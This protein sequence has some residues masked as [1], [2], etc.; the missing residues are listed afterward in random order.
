M[1]EGVTTAESWVKFQKIELAVPFQEITVH[2]P[3]VRQSGSNLG[4]H[5]LERLRS[6]RY[7]LVGFT[8]T[9]GKLL[10]S[11]EANKTLLPTIQNI[12]AVFRPLD[13][14]LNNHRILGPQ[15]RQCAFRHGLPAS[16]SEE[17]TSE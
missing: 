4:N 15:R 2:I 13:D 16:R 17:H 3:P 12:H 5:L 11:G 8:C 7:R 1:S 14:F 6:H 10:L 9:H